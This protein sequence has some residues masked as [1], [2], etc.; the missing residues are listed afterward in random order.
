[1]LGLSNKLTLWPRLGIVLSVLWLVVVPIWQT[2]R[3]A[4][5]VLEFDQ[6]LQRKC[7]DG[8]GGV[9]CD[10]LPM[11]ITDHQMWNYWLVHLMVAG[12]WVVLGWIFA[13]AAFYTGRWVL[14]G[15]RHQNSNRETTAPDDA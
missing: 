2:L 8:G 4:D 14:A 6:E 12:V 10:S 7:I 3:K 13:I 11:G 15:R 1:M 5:L 9:R